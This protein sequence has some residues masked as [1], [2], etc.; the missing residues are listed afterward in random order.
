[1]YGRYAVWTN[2]GIFVISAKLGALIYN[3]PYYQGGSFVTGLEMGWRYRIG[4]HFVV[5]PYLGC[6][7]CA[8]DRYLMPF[9]VS[10][11]TELLIP[12]FNAGVRLGIGF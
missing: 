3:S 5:E 6:D 11:L 9:T 2:R 7:V 4:G 8:D 1:L 10:S 12:G